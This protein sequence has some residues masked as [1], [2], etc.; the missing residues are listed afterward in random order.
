MTNCSERSLGSTYRIP[1]YYVLTHPEKCTSD[2]EA[3]THSIDGFNNKFWENAASAPK[4][5]WMELTNFVV[6]IE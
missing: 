1:A 3:V 2:V 4:V 6:P 5:H